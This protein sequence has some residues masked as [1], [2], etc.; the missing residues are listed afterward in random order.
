MTNKHPKSRSLISP[1]GFNRITVPF[2]D[3]GDFQSDD[4]TADATEVYGDW[5]QI[6]TP[7]DRSPVG[8]CEYS[9]REPDRCIHCGRKT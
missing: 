7:C 4:P 2:D 9:A 3:P 5:P 6:D 1:F 8:Q